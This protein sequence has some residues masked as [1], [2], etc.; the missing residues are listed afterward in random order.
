MGIPALLGE[1]RYA[2]MVHIKERILKKLAA[3]KKGLITRSGREVLIKEAACAILMYAMCNPLYDDWCLCS[4]MKDENDWE[5]K[6][7][8]QSERPKKKKGYRSEMGFLVFLVPKKENHDRNLLTSRRD[9]RQSI[10]SFPSP[11]SGNILKRLVK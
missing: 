5:R 2:A 6:D 8:R 11:G 10:C 3:W 4:P 9:K 1:T 7:K